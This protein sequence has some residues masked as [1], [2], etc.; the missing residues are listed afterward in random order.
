MA[1]TPGVWILLGDNAS[2]LVTLGPLYVTAFQFVDDPSQLEGGGVGIK[3]TF[4]F[5]GSGIEDEPRLTANGL[6]YYLQNLNRIFEVAD[7]AVTFTDEVVGETSKPLVD[8]LELTHVVLVEAIRNPNSLL[9]LEHELYA[10]A[11]RFLEN[12]L[13]LTDAADFE[14]IRILSSNIPL[15]DSVEYEVIYT[16][17]DTISFTDLAQEV[18]E[19]LDDTLTLTQTVNLNILSNQSLTDTVSLTQVVIVEQR[20]IHQIT[21]T[22]QAVKQYIAIR[23]IQDTL[24]FSEHI[25]IQ[26]TCHLSGS[27]TLTDTLVEYLQYNPANDLE[28][29]DEIEYIHRHITNESI[30]HNINLSQTFSLGLSGRASSELNLTHSLGYQLTPKCCRI[31]SYAPLVEP[32]PL[33]LNGEAIVPMK[34]LSPLDP[35]ALQNTVSYTYPFVSPTLT[36]TLNAPEFGNKE[37]NAQKRVLRPTRGGTLKNYK[38]KN[39]AKYTRLNLDFEILKEQDYLDLLNFLSTSLGDEIGFRDHEGRVWKG[40]I[41]NPNTAISQVSTEIYNVSLQLEGSI[42]L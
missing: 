6:Y 39:W 36:L 26:L 19:L 9:E 29:S 10:Y 33:T 13:S 31:Y 34:V 25:N 35:F 7:N 17:S 18:G 5:L 11:Q 42:V 23:S 22:D 16:V 32:N 12:N 15:T 2:G 24:S 1:A 28:L 3:P 27:L 30:T 20:L 37:L 14:A 41:T 38:S 21:F 4:A 40:I 8:N